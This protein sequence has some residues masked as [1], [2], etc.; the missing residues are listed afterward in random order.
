MGSAGLLATTPGRGAVGNALRRAS[1]KASNARARRLV[2]TA[3]STGVLNVQSLTVLQRTAGN[4]AV[5]RMLADESHHAAS[6]TRPTVQRCGDHVEPGC[7][8]AE[9]ASAPVEVQRD[10]QV[11]ASGLSIDERYESALATAR[12]TADFRTAAELLN[13]F[14]RADV[15]GRLAR[16]S[17]LDVQYL[18]LGATGNPAVGAGSQVAVLTRPGAPRASTTAGPGSTPPSGQKPLAN[19]LAAFKR[20]VR[21]AG[22][23]RLGQSSRALEQ[24]RRFLEDQLTPE[25]VQG[26]V[27]AEE[28]RSVLATATRGGLAETAL[29][30]QWLQTRGA[31]TRWV[32]Q[33]QIEGRYRACSGCHAAVRADL[34]DRGLLEQR[35]QVPTPLEQ[36]AAVPEGP[37]PSLAEG[38]E[39]TQG[40]APAPF[41]RVAQAQLRLAAIR[42][43]LRQLG[44]D[45]YRVLPPETLG[46][47]APPSTLMADITNR[48]T[49]RQAGYQEFIRR[50]DGADFD[51]LQLRPIV[52]E[53]LPLAD[54][55]VRAAVE[56]EIDSAEAW[57]T[58][59]TIV[60]GAATIALLLL[61]VF[62]PTSPIGVGGALAL[63]AA[64]GGQQ[65]YRGY[66]SYEL[67]RLYS[68]GRGADEVL[69]PAQQEAADSLM[70]VGVLNVVLGSVGVASS[71]LGAVRLVRALPPTGGGLGAI[72]SVEASA[73]GRYYQVTGWGTRELRVTVLEPNGQVVR[74]GTLAAFESGASGATRPPTS[75]AGGAFFPTEGGAARVAVPVLEVVPPPVAAPAAVPAT[76]PAT[77]A[78][79]SPPLSIRGLLAMSAA[80]SAAG[81]VA[82]RA[83]RRQ[84]VM[85]A[86][87]TATEQQQ[88]RDCN[89]LHNKY[90]DTQGAGADLSA[91]MDPLQDRIMNNRFSAQD[92]I[93]F[94]LLL[95][96]R[97]RLVQQEHRDRLRYIR[98]DCDSIDWFPEDGRSAAE[99][100][101]DHLAALDNV[102]A[103][104]DN[105][106]RV[107]AFKV[108][109]LATGVFGRLCPP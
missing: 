58:V 103:Q 53:L 17:D 29:A 62:P 79:A 95:A 97:I 93:D 101:A 99:R 88:W 48:I 81:A 8:C 44:E 109:H 30:D 21:D 52:R 66:Q 106:Y 9:E 76:V 31:N 59:E 47:T 46:S 87:L 22:K 16:L 61:A 7:T 32:Q 83:T 82:T 60:V 49:R 10:P 27:H 24:W 12:E 50:I 15:L 73:G 67:G 1:P 23:L 18:H 14:D 45:G 28:V 38:D 94:C 108:R 74:Q 37:R 105:Y 64:V 41:P 34:M 20:L 92:H 65:I 39:G 107:E 54:P 85:R 4:R 91:R 63:G 25:Q 84:P 51:Y 96:A 40:T 80:T 2:A 35:G 56:D 98:M 75:G 57:E 86:G 36:L 5:S 6:E 3:G 90:K 72:D 71:A 43:Y 89:D 100:L 19:R 78:P 68:L 102:K 11:S 55:A 26:Q 77:V 69:D 42:P 33:Q 70:A 13:G 104:L